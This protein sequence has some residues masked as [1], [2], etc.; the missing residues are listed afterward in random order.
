MAATTDHEPEV[1]DGHHGETHPHAK[2]SFYFAVA[3]ILALVTA[4]EVVLSYVGLEGLA[5]LLPLG[6]LMIVKFAMVAAL[7]MH[8]KGD[9]RLFTRF[10]LTGIVLAA[11]VY[12][13]VLLTFETFSG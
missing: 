10:F 7:F 3:G 4:A 1:F 6:V 13:I 5:L 11:I 2:D 9:N 8:L 12:V